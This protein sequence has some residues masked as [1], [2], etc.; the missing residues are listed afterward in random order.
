MGKTWEN[1]RKFQ[2]KMME[3]DDIPSVSS[4]LAEKPIGKPQEDHRKMVVEWDG[5]EPSGFIKH[6]WNI[7]KLNGGF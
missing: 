4:N 3:N 1:H 5:V 7:P 2:R 6:G